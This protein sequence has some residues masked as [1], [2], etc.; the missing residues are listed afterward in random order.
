[1]NYSYCIICQKHLINNFNAY[2]CYNGDHEYYYNDSNNENDIDNKFWMIA[3]NDFYIDK[4]K[5]CNNYTRELYVKF[6]E[7]ISVYDAATILKRFIK[8]K[9]FL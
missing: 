1:M 3:I 5:I 9:Y 4:S 6:D 8:L 2:H 7:N